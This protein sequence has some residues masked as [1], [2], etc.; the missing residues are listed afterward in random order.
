MKN[1]QRVFDAT[2][3]NLQDHLQVQHI[4]TF[5][6]LTCLGDDHPSRNPQSLPGF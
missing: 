2:M 1:Q 4:A 3:K 6:L 5:N